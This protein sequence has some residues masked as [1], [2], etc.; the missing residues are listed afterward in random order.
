AA[1]SGGG[2]G[3]FDAHAVE[4][5]LFGGHL[6]NGLVMAMPVDKRP[7]WQLGKREI[8]CALLEKLAEQKDLLREGL[9]AFVFGEKVREFV[10]E[11]GGAAGFED[12]DGRCG[13]DFG[14]K[15]VHDLEEQALGSVEHANVVERAAAAEV[16]AGD[17]DGEAG[18]FQDFDGGFGG[19]GEEV[20]VESVG[21]EEDGAVEL[22][23]TGR[24]RAAVPT[25]VVVSLPPLFER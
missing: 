10:A 5:R 8:F 19:R 16:G 15:L 1:A 17:G 25:W 3:E 22:R 4:D 6:Q 2:R 23:S 18:G 20:V 7:A 9:R 24:P 14:E 11:D 12:D 21:P 13:F